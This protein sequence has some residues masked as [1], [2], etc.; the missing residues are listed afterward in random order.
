MP[1]PSKLKSKRLGV[2]GSSRGKDPLPMQVTITNKGRLELSNAFND[3][4]GRERGDIVDGE[5]LMV[6]KYAYVEFY[7]DEKEVKLHIGFVSEADEG[8]RKSI[9]YSTTKIGLTITNVLRDVGLELPDIGEKY[10]FVID[11]DDDVYKSIITEVGG[12]H[13]G[14]SL[15]VNEKERY[16]ILDWN[17]KLTIPLVPR[18]RKQKE[19]SEENKNSLAVKMS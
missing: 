10:L 8:Y 6:T 18:P 11:P 2:T 5:P 17:N 19:N 15:E 16:I 13:N 1:L 4:L 7:Y 3:M 14:S 12:E 9:G